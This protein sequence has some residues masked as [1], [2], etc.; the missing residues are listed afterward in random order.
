MERKLS[1]EKY[2]GHIDYGSRFGITNKQERSMSRSFLYSLNLID[3]TQVII[4][5]LEK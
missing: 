2:S 4:S 3:G 5:H 1:H